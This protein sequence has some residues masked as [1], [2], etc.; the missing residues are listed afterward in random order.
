MAIPTT[1]SGNGSPPSDRGGRTFAHY[2][3]V[4]DLVTSARPLFYETGFAAGDAHGFGGGEAFTLRLEGADG[5]TLQDATITITA[6]QNFSDIITD[7]NNV[8][9]GLGAYGTFGLTVPDGELQFTPAAN[10]QGAQIKVL[11]DTTQRGGGARSFT[12]MFGVGEGTRSVRAFNPQIRSDID[13]NPGRLSVGRI[14]LTG[15]TLGDIVTGAGDG[16]GASALQAAGSTNLAFAAAGGFSATTTTVVN[17]AGRVAGDMGRRAN[18]A[19]RIAESAEA[20]KTEAHD[21]RTSA[22]GVNIEEELVKLTTFQQSF[23]AASRLILAAK[24]MSDTLINM[25]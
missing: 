14:D 2:F 7:L 8:G 22:E 20:I 15:A 1:P 23:N 24:E 21:R 12:E 4:N 10:Y 16:S 5:A 18:N 13:A 11:D 9:A 17:F 3:G 6:G 25:V 19:E